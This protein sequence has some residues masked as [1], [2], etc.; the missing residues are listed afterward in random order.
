MTY[1][2]DILYSALLYFRWVGIIAITILSM[3]I[4]ISEAAKSKLSPA[5]I[6]TVA[7]SGLLAAILFWVLPVVI[8]YARRDVTPIVPAGPIGTVYE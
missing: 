4:L 2:G 8:D 1:L 6:L 3:A 5:K 7:G